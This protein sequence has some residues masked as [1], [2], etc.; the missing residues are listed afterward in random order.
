[1]TLEEQYIELAINVLKDKFGNISPLERLRYLDKLKDRYCF[2]CGATMIGDICTT[3]RN[4][5]RK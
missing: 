3:C 2:N 5:N 4:I 1:M